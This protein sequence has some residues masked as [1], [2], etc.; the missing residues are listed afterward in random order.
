IVGQ[1]YGRVESIE[2][3]LEELGD[4]ATG[5]EGIN[6]ALVELTGRP[7]RLPVRIRVASCPASIR[8]D[9]AWSYWLEGPDGRVTAPL[10]LEVAAE[11]WLRCWWPALAALTGFLALGVCVY[12]FASP[13]RF[14]PRAGVQLCDE[15]NVDE[16]FFHPF[17]AQRGSGAGFFRDARLFLHADFRLSGAAAGALVALHARRLGVTLEGIAAVERRAADGTWERLDDVEKRLRP[18]VVHRTGAVFFAL[19]HG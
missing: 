14:P 13:A 3:H 16:G 9:A 11:P 15:D 7:K 10:R 5:L 2:R 17:R 4:G 8:G 18:G 1:M 19:R 6:G 12:G